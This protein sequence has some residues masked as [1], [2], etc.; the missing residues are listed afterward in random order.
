VPLAVAGFN[1]G[2]FKVI[3]VKLEKPEMQVLS[4]A[5]EAPPAWVQSLQTAVENVR[6]PGTGL[7]ISGG[8]GA[9]NDAMG[10]ALGNMST[11]DLSK[12]ALGE[13]ELAVRI[14]SDFFGPVA[15]KRLEI[16][17]Q[18]ATNFGQSWPGLVFLPMSYLF[19]TTTR[20][21]LG[22]IMRRMYPTYSDDPYGYFKVV[23]PHEVAHQWWGQTVGFNS[24]RDQ[25]TSTS[26]MMSDAC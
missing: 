14:Y 1:F 19:D 6:D 3:D 4:Y 10:G 8:A 5:N 17:Q 2:K 7:L 25:C 23:A 22:N 9:M 26:G 24:Y 18:T 21:A 15:Y 12:K 20:H 16:T 13:A 11:V